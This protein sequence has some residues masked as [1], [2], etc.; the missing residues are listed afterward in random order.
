MGRRDR[1]SSSS[2]ALGHTILEAGRYLGDQIGCILAPRFLASGRQHLE[3]SLRRCLQLLQF[4]YGRRGGLRSSVERLRRPRARVHAAPRPRSKASG[5]FA[6]PSDVVHNET[7][8]KILQ[9]LLG[10]TVIEPRTSGCPLRIADQVAPAGDVSSS[11]SSSSSNSPSSRFF[12]TS[13]A[14]QIEIS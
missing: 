6:D 12:S 11:A 10:R 1:R 14:I 3:A 13:F 2:L 5:S 9:V 8:S 7:R 4:C